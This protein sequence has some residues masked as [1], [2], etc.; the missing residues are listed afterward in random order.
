MEGR[1]LAV[2]LTCKHIS[3]MVTVFPV[4]GGPNIMYGPRPQLSASRVPTACCCCSFNL[5]LMGSKEPAQ[6]F[7]G[8]PN[9]LNRRFLDCRRPLVLGI[10]FWVWWAV[11]EVGFERYEWVPELEF[12]GDLTGWLAVCPHVQGRR[13]NGA[14]AALARATCIRCRGEAEHSA[15]EDT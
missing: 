5:M 15:T 8:P 3:T 2:H 6:F 14:R 12:G 10:W 9:P 11:E 4:P 1:Q 7:S 13:A